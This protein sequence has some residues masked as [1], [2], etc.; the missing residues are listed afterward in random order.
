MR[1]AA[2]VRSSPFRRALGRLVPDWAPDEIPEAEP[3]VLVTAE[4]ILRVLRLLAGATATVLL[5]EDS[6][7]PTPRA[8]R[9]AMDIP[10]GRFATLSDPQGAVFSIV[11]LA[12]QPG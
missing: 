12:E 3:S 11:Q 2:Q 4:G 1:S 10:V 5:L 7:G 9:P 8:W 6:T